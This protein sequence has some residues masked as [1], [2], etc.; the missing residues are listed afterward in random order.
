VIAVIGII[1]ALRFG[2]RG[3]ITTFFNVYLDT[4]LGT[5]PV[6]IGALVA[7]GQLLSV[8][9]AFAAPYAVS[10]WGPRST[11]TWGTA[12][13]ALAAIPLAL[14]PTWLGAGLGY[15]GSSV[16]LT[17]TVGPL[18]LFG[19]ELVAPRWRPSMAAVFMMGAGLAFSLMSMVGGYAVIA[20]GYRT[21]F[22]IAVVLTA[23]AAVLF[24]LYF[25]RARG[26]MDQG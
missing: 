25:S 24:R 5:S 23:A 18:R 2:G 7:A 14:V 6:L 16:M 13:T 1:M 8:P 22:W 15:V 3:S 12:A 17:M 4:E 9:A 26:E 20:L 11:I 21:L 19:Q 10:R